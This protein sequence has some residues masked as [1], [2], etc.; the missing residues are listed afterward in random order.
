MNATFIYIAPGIMHTGTMYINWNTFI[1]L[2]RYKME[3]NVLGPPIICKN[4][5]IV[6][7][8]QLIYLR[9]LLNL[10]KI[11]KYFDKWKTFKVAVDRFLS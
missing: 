11:I 7:H 1:A 2:T 5:I 9:N 6:T 8:G 10:S 4:A 3:K